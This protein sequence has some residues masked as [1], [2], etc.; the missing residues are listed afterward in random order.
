MAKKQYENK[1]RISIKISS[2]YNHHENVSNEIPMSSYE[3]YVETANEISIRCE[4]ISA[5]IENM[6]KLLFDKQK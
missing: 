2:S 3:G 1:K 5:E 6:R 4:K